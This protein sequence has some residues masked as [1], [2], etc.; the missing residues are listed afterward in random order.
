MGSNFEMEPIIPMRWTFDEGIRASCDAFS[1]AIPDGYRILESQDDNSEDNDITFSAVPKANEDNETSFRIAIRIAENLPEDA[2]EE[3]GIDELV[4][5]M[6]RKALNDDESMF[7][8]NSPEHWVAQGK[9]CPV[10]VTRIYSQLFGLFTRNSY[11]IRPISNDMSFRVEITMDEMNDDIAEEMHEP[12]NALVSSIETTKPLKSNLTKMLDKIST[13][14]VTPQE[15][16]E[17]VNHLVKVVTLC[18]DTENTANQLEYLRNCDEPNGYDA[19]RAVVMGM[20]DF[21]GRIFPMFVRTFD[22]IEF[23]RS[24]GCT[25]DELTSYFEV[26]KAMLEPCVTICDAIDQQSAQFLSEHGP[27]ALPDGFWKMVD[28]IDMQLPGTRSE[29]EMRIKAANEQFQA[30]IE[31]HINKA[32]NDNEESDGVDYPTLMMT[33]LSDDWFF[34]MDDEITWDGHHHAIAGAQLNGAKADEL[35]DFVNSCIPGFDD[36]NEVFQYFVTLLN[37]IEKDEGLIVPRAIIAPGV[38][39]AIREGDLTGLTLANLAACG[40]AFCVQKVGS[41]SYRVI[42]DGRLILGIPRFLDLVA[43]LLWDLRQCTNSMRGKPFEICFLQA[44]N[45]DA[46]H[47]LGSVE[48][49]VPGAQ[50]YAMSMKVTEAPR[51]ALPSASEA[52]EYQ[53]QVSIELS[54]E[55]DMALN[56][57]C[58]LVRDFPCTKPISG[59]HHLGRAGRIEH[60]K[61]G[62][63]L[64]LAADWNCEFFDPAGVEVFNEQGETLGYLEGVIGPMR[65]VLALILPH[66]TATVESVTPLSKRKKGS[67]YALMDVHME[68]DDDATVEG[69][70]NV[71]PSS[72]LLA[73]AR[74]LLIQPK[75]ERTVMSHANIDISQLKGRIDVSSFPQVESATSEVSHDETTA[76]TPSTADRTERQKNRE[77]AR[78]EYER[79]RNER[80]VAEEEAATAERIEQVRSAIEGF[81]EEL[82]VRER[83]IR[84]A[85]DAAC[86]AANDSFD[87]PAR[88]EALY[89][90][91]TAELERDLELTR[92]T[93]FLHAIDNMGLG[94][95]DI[96]SL[97]IEHGSA[98]IGP[99]LKETESYVS[100]YAD[101]LVRIRE[102]RKNDKFWAFK[103]PYRDRILEHLIET[104]EDLTRQQIEEDLDETEGLYWNPP[105]DPGLK[106]VDFE[107][108]LRNIP[109]PG[110]DTVSQLHYRRMLM[111]ESHG[112][113]KEISRLM[114]EIEQWEEMLSGDLEFTKSERSALE[115]EIK[116]LQDRIVQAES[117]AE[118]AENRERN[119]LKH[120]AL[121]YIK[122]QAT[123][124]PQNAEIERAA[125]LATRPVAKPEKTEPAKS[126]V[127]TDSAQPS[128]KP[129]TAAAPA[130]TAASDV[131]A[132]TSGNAAGGLILPIA[133]VIGFVGGCIYGGPFPG[134]LLAAFTTISAWITINELKK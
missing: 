6:F 48:A 85:T 15:F 101:R 45:I 43:R 131:T 18:K 47:Y 12:I 41:G 79:L 23:Q 30:A 100:D 89:R 78:T 111:D 27:I 13:Q 44:R 122:D 107:A 36:V 91:Y 64:I 4:I 3:H 33:L 115:T 93:R 35:L 94:P 129:N 8:P 16:C 127:P 1:I 92:L 20:E 39:K 108:F 130:A 2:F 99:L 75:S 32:P 25:E 50:K 46:D 5:A 82:Q 31:E 121:F 58:A 76:K 105:E 102:N 133:A 10:L 106:L 81:K 124:I 55:D 66:V 120:R 70:L 118:M 21:L 65:G 19:T 110:P 72:E 116:A 117:L 134:F 34:F 74:G 128:E 53:E 63:S 60:V 54:P 132:N 125:F 80:R 103:K 123:V 11:L 68:L 37:E 17:T 28:S 97:P 56:F 69:I 113:Q 38:Q 29:M 119:Y 59:T 61:V 90:F 114:A 62:D 71:D 104:G 88:R 109:S 84:D 49:P 73:Q 22:A 26:A 96:S 52:A 112:A 87:R 14:K 40:K 42:F 86:R 24:F 77:A 51:I 83:S 98:T 9:N 126:N 95:I 7:I 57:V 67:K